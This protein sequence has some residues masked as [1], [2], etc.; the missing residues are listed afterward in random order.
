M[1]FRP[2][3]PAPDATPGGTS[4]WRGAFA[5]LLTP[6]TLALA[7][8]APF[9]LATVPASAAVVISQVYGGGGNT[10]AVY[11]ADFVELYNNGSAPVSVGNWSVQYASATG[12]SWQVTVIPAGLTIQ[13]GGYLL[14]REA[15]GTGGTVDV[16]S[17][18]TG[19]IP[20]S[21]TAGKVALSGNNI[22]LSGAAPTGG[23]LQDIVSFG[24]A[25]PTEGTP[26]GALSNTTAALRNS[27]GC[28]DTNNNVADFTIG[29]PNPRN[30][31]F[32]A[33]ACSG[34]G[35]GDPGPTPVAAAIYKIQ[36]S[37]AQSP[38]V[39]Q[40]VITSGVVTKVTNNGF[41][42]QDLT[43]DGDPSTSDGVFVFTSTAP[44]ATAVV[45]NL[46]Q[47]TATVSEFSAGAGTAAT[48]R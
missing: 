23:L 15:L 19:T 16:P 4:A 27:N 46:V 11:R 20:L 7:L 38:L 12:T 30:S 36:G 40:V 2:D 43:G 29:T 33:A 45:G 39:G 3:V 22:A 28:T 41:F 25:T 9:A 47:V 32:M 35:G 26:V 31:T 14:V 24:A 44:P 18:V 5:R 37:G 42:I 48:P 17:D 8:A 1:L 13:A 10:G 6:G 21:A 34:G